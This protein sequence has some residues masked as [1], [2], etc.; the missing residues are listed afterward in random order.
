MPRSKADNNPIIPKPK[1]SNTTNVRKTAKNIPIQI[2][3]RAAI[4]ALDQ[5]YKFGSMLFESIYKNKITV[6]TGA[7][8][9]AVM[10][11]LLK[12]F[13]VDIIPLLE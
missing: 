1:N 2:P 5:I 6:N 13:L 8:P 10:V 11:S 3:I 9:T 4:A 12:I 7:I